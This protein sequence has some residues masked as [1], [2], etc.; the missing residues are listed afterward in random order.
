MNILGLKKKIKDFLIT[1]YDAYF[2]IVYNETVGYALVRNN[3]KPF[4]LT[5]FY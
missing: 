2:F 4:Y 5:V 3:S 1:E